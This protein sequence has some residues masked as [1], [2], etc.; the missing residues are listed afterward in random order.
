MQKESS[1]LPC[2]VRCD[3]P[4]SADGNRCSTRPFLSLDTVHPLEDI[5]S[6]RCPLG[7][8]VANHACP[9]S[10][11]TSTIHS[12]SMNWDSEKRA[13]D[14]RDHLPGAELERLCRGDRSWRDSLP[15]CATSSQAS[16]DDV[17]GCSSASSCG[18]EL[19][20]CIAS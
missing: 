7:R 6:T 5:T 13:T 4:G 20:R 19:D 18:L 1:A 2:F 11:G 9:R 12:G 17:P 14:S 8:G 3:P 16:V 10:G 15:I